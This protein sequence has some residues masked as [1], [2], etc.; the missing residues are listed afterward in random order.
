[1]LAS[2]DDVLF[3][4]DLMLVRTGGETETPADVR[5]ESLD[6]LPMGLPSATNGLRIMPEQTARKHTIKLNIVVE[7]DS[8]VAQREIA[9]RRGSRGCSI[10]ATRLSS[11]QKR[12][13]TGSYATESF[14]MWNDFEP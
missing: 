6:G 3:L 7:A 11:G 12:S 4:A 13:L 8:L 9:R 14:K 1:V 5:F 2:R 10:A